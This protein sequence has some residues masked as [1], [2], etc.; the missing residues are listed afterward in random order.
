VKKWR[1]DRMNLTDEKNENISQIF[2]KY[3]ELA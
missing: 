3:K 1:M 2:K